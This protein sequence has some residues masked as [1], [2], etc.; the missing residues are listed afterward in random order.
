M[1]PGVGC[2][3]CLGCFLVCPWTRSCGRG[4]VAV[5]SGVRG[6]PGPALRV[7]RRQEI[8]FLADGTLLSFLT[9]DSADSGRRR[10]SLH[11]RS[12]VTGR[13]LASDKGSGWVHILP[14]CLCRARLACR[15]PCVLGLRQL[16]LR[17]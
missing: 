3:P 10:N 5:S 9:L 12:G 2:P 17:L 4:A 6:D 15:G 16:N 7:P 14:A 8:S 1:W 11:I 13:H